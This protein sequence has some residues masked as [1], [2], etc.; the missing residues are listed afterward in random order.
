M[1]HSEEIVI[2]T[3]W[4]IAIIASIT[5]HSA[6]TLLIFSVVTGWVVGGIIGEWVIGYHYNKQDMHR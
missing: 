6:L 3:S 5:G 1:D 4:L 2:V